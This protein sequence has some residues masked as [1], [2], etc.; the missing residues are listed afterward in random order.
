LAT[1]GHKAFR[2]LLV[3]PELR[4]RLDHKAIKVSLVLRAYKEFK[5]LLELL[6]L[7]V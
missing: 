6:A 5:A 3:S 4:D 2:D 1:Q 7:L